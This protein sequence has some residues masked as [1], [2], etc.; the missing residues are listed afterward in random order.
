MKTWNQFEMDLKKK[1][2]N[3][4]FSGVVVAHVGGHK[5]FSVEM[6]SRNASEKAGILPTDAFR[7]GCLGKQF[8][9][10]AFLKLENEGKID[11]EVPM[12]SLIPERHKSLIRS[13]FHK[14]RLIHLLNGT[15]GLSS[16][17]RTERYASHVH[18]KSFRREELLEACLHLECDAPPGTIFREALGPTI[19]ASICLEELTGLPVD[20]SIKQ[21][22][23]TDLDS[24]GMDWKKSLFPLASPHIKKGDALELHSIFNHDPNFSCLYGA[25]ALYANALDLVCWFENLIAG[26]ILG[27]AA[28]ARMM[29]EGLG[30]YGLG[31]VCWTAKDGTRRLWH[32][33]GASGYAADLIGV[34]EREI[35]VC[36][37]QNQGFTKKRPDVAQEA[38]KL[39]LLGVNE[40]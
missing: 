2:E 15:S 35:V 21:L 19:L 28:T 3:S 33:G 9:A 39:T 10:A 37:L 16:L 7:I 14:I 1:F 24:L 36:V 20:L 34:P 12:V 29:R 13:E 4:D 38:L 40:C 25:C 22:T 27:P 11:L 8:L 30:S 32:H 18:T 23:R 26:A 31:I 5:V 17:R 6:G